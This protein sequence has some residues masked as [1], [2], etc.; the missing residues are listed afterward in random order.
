MGAAV[1]FAAA[2]AAGVRGIML[3]VGGGMAR[4][5]GIGPSICRPG[6]GT[7]IGGGAL[8]GLIWIHGDTRPGAEGFP[9]IGMVEAAAMEA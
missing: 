1:R 9:R 8:G 5:I 2:L 6:L 7:G 3:T 4:L